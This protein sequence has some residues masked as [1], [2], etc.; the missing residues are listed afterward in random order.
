MNRLVS[1]GRVAAMVAIMSL[2]LA[3]Y[4]YFLYDLHDTDNWN[5]VA[6]DSF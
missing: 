6:G 3:I 5:F 4:M 1:P 2:I